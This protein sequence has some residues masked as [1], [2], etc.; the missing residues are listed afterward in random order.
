M[1]YVMIL[2]PYNSVDSRENLGE[3]AKEEMLNL[4]VNEVSNGHAKVR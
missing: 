2:L 1:I 3:K 4:V